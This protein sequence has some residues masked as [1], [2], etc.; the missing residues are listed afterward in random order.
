MFTTRPALRDA[1]GA[2]ASTPRPASPA[3]TAAR[4]RGGDAVEA[5][6]SAGAHPHGMQGMQAHAVGR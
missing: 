3:G 6:V 2:V 5:A 4:Q 1:H